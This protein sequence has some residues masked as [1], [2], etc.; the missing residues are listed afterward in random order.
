MTAYSI[1]NI[2][3]KM[4]L[5]LI[6][7]KLRIANSQFRLRTKVTVKLVKFKNFS[8]EGTGTLST[9]TKFQ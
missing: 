4:I 8:H 2:I 1:L 6:L 7:Y 3:R 9:I 5:Y